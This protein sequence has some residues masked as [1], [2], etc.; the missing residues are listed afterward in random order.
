MK[1][2]EISPNFQCNLRCLGCLPEEVPDVDM[3]PAEIVRWLRLGRQKGATGAWFGGGEPTLR[4]DLPRLVAAAK[5]LGYEEVKLQTNG[6]LLG[7]G[8]VCERLVRAGTTSVNLVLRSWREEVHET[9]VKRRGSFQALEKA[10]TVLKDSPL[11]L[12]GDILLSRSNLE[13][14]PRTLE[15]YLARG[16]DVFNIWYLCLFDPADRVTAAEIAPYRDAAP[17]IVEAIDRALAAGA[18]QVLSLHTPACVLPESHWQHL[19]YP[20]ELELLVVN[21]DGRAF[22]L[23]DSPVEGGSPLP[24]CE[25][26]S[27]RSRCLGPRADYMGIFG[28]DEFKPIGDS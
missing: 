22:M 13:D 4:R 7:V 18:R 26:C 15:H 1:W 20:P 2:I 10:I 5:K 9:M 14:L 11:A 8:D 23:E 17:I 6:L 28:E 24:S 27:R 12:E 25:A 3:A 16:I 21:A 19:Y